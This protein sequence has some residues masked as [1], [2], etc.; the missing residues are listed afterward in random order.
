MN[1]YLPLKLGL[2][3]TNPPVDISQRLFTASNISNQNW[4]SVFYC[5]EYLC[6][7]MMILIYKQNKQWED[8]ELKVDIYVAHHIFILMWIHF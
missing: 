8:K 1:F 7:I 2:N 4:I 3:L 5:T 6:D